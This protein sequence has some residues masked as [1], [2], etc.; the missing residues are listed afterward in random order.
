MS[1][2]WIE[3][4][5]G[6]C[7][8]VVMG[9]LSSPK[10]WM[11]KVVIALDVFFAAILLNKEKITISSWAGIEAPKGNRVAR[12]LVKFLEWV[13]PGHCQRAVA[14]DIQRAQLVILYL[15]EGVK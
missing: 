4:F 1:I 9:L 7:A 6:I 5:A 2:W 15:S 14:F 11:R 12:V 10:T 3:F 8:V 13:D